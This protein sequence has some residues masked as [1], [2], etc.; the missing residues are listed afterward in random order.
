M[1]HMRSEDETDTILDTAEGQAMTRLLNSREWVRQ[2]AHS[3]AG[4]VKRLEM[5]RDAGLPPMRVVAVAEIER[6]GRIPHA[7]KPQHTAK[8]QPHGG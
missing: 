5:M 3:H 8:P 2:N 7:T 6:L 1:A 4:L